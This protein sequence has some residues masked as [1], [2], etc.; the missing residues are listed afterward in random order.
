MC[1]VFI[2]NNVVILCTDRNKR[3]CV[4]IA[5]RCV[6]ALAKKL[7]SQEA[8]ILLFSKTEPHRGPNKRIKRRVCADEASS[9]LMESFAIYHT[10]N[11]SDALSVTFEKKEKEKKRER[12]RERE[13][14][15]KRKKRRTRGTNNGGEVLRDDK[16]MDP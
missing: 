6:S 16:K 15:R 5:P 9:R 1:G 12:E 13:R 11:A 4:K 3:I 2:I 8:S 10:P 7:T 14:R